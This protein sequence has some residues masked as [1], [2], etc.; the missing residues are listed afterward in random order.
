[1]KEKE[2]TNYFDVFNRVSKFAFDWL[3]N[4]ILLT[5]C[6]DDFSEFKK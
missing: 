3:N 6:G 1:M 4:L 5:Y 2:V